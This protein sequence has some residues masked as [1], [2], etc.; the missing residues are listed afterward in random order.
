MASMD[1]VPPVYLLT[2]DSLRADFFDP[3]RFP[4]CWERFASDFARF[5]DAYANGI[6]TPLAFP[7]ILADDHVTGNGVIDQDATTIAELVGGTSVGLG[8]N[9]H[10][11]RERGYDRGFSTF[12]IDIGAR[13]YITRSLSLASF[14]QN[15]RKHVQRRL[16]L[17]KDPVV[18]VLYR[19]AERMVYELKRSIQSTDP[20]YLWGHFMDPHGPYHP[21]LVFDR[22]LSVSFEPKGFERV[23]RKWK[24]DVDMTDR[25]LETMVHIYEE[26]I[27]YLDR[28]LIDLFGWLEAVGRYE[29]SLI[30]ITADHGQ[31]I[32]EGG[33]FGHGWNNLPEDELLRVPLLVKF[34]DE[35][36]AGEVLSHQVQHLDISST[37]AVHASADADLNPDSRPLTDPNDRFIIAKSNSGVRGISQN[38]DVLRSNGNITERGSDPA[39]VER[40]RSATP[41]RVTNDVGQG[42]MTKDEQERVNERLDALGY[43]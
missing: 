18:P 13:G 22:E 7:S 14:R 20:T 12:D 4:S 28:Q 21:D 10:L 24:D 2:I 40:V 11:S 1:D 41:V 8:N 17:M 34:P 9:V 19:P 23:N 16:P 38:G 33:R 39:L 43:R 37:V 30:I 36:Y 42:T 26:K 27:G 5:S 29:D 3:D 35:S 6:A 31:F 25:E 32:G 15:I